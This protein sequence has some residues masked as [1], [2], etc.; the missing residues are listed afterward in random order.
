MPDAVNADPTVPALGKPGRRAQPT[1]EVQVAAMEQPI[2][3]DV[4]FV[5]KA[6]NHQGAANNERHSAHAPV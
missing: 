1:R 4:R 2:E 3:G 5:A 6:A